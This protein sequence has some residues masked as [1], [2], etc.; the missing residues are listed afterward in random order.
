MGKR[1]NTATWNEKYN[2]WQINVQKD[3]YRRSFYSSAP[4]RT[5]QREANA[6]ADA[7]LDSGIIGAASNIEKLFSEFEQANK[8][9]S[10]PRQRRRSSIISASG[11][12]RISGA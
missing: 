1:T 3:G 2:R 9:L 5:G 10:G 6:K 7:W 11:S 4:G 12:C 8:L